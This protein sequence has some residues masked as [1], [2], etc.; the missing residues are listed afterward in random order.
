M[1]KLVDTEM[2][3]MQIL[4]SLA[5][6]WLPAKLLFYMAQ[7]SHRSKE[8]IWMFRKWEGCSAASMQGIG[9]QYH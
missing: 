6:P 4:L 8:P 7:V 5:P 1:K 2:A 3:D 9:K